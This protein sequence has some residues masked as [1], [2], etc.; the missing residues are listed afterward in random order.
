MNEFPKA[1]LTVVSNIEEE[2]RDFS[3]PP[4]EGGIAHYQAVLAMSLVKNTRTY[5]VRLVHQING[6][7]EGGWY[8]ACAVMIRRL[9]ETLIIEVFEAHNI[10]D[11][12]KDSNGN[13]LYLR[14]L[15]TALLKEPSWHIGRTTKNALP[16]LKDF[17]D[18]SAH[19]RRFLAQRKDID[20]VQHSL[21]TVVQELILLANLQKT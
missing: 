4:P 9:L 19:S 1:I 15:V 18:Q 20:D 13:Y 6:S 17:G 3:K 7:Y 11:N 14:D 5:I 16:K 2:I 12:I 8:D 10:A 21:R